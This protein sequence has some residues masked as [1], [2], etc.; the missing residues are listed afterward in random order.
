[1]RFAE[2]A[3]ITSCTQQTACH[4]LVPLLMRQNAHSFRVLGLS[5][6]TETEGVP[7]PQGELIV[8]WANFIAKHPHA[9]VLLGRTRNIMQWRSTAMAKLIRA[10]HPSGKFSLRRDL[11]D[12]QGYLLIL[13]GFELETDAAK[14]AALLGAARVEAY[15]GYSSAFEFDPAILNLQPRR[16]RIAK[17]Q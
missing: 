12:E 9:H 14:L 17:A 1:M 8:N 10:Q 3:R 13:V 2:R 15:A 6:V 11:D 16:K 7:S 5:N 4:I